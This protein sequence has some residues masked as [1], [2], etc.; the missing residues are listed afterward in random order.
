MKYKSDYKNILIFSGVI[1]LFAIALTIWA[2]DKVPN[3]AQIPVHWNAKGEVDGYRGKTIGLLMGP[4]T[5]FFLSILLAF[6]PRIDPRLKNLQ[7]SQKA[8]EIV[9]GGVV[10]F[11]AILHLITIL[12]VLGYA[13]N[14]SA[15]MAFL[16]GILFMAIGNYLGK[17]RSNFMFGI[18]TAWTLSSEISWNKTHRLGGWLFFITGLLVFLSGLWRNGELTFG[19][20]FAG[21]LSSVILLFGYSYWVWKSDEERTEN[22][23]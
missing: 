18:R 17:V 13:I 19:L 3:D 8:Y 2:W 6:L 22:K 9:W 21:T 20:L 10:L 14:M 5:V 15:A 4:A 1:F 7:Q 12:S 11:M 23:K 16:L